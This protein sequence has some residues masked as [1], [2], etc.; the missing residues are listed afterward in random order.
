MSAS[1]LM[2]FSPWRSSMRCRTPCVEGCCGPMWSE[3][4][5]VV[6][7]SSL[8]AI[9]RWSG[10]PLFLFFAV[11]VIPVLVAP[12]RVVLAKRITFPVLRKVDALQAG[13]SLKYYPEHIVDFPFGPVRAEPDGRD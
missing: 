6:I 7:I 12:E 10:Q 8:F 1:A 4:S 9:F 2:T 5:F 11:G 13:M 3:I